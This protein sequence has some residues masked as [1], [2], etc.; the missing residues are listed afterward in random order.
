MF[1]ALKKKKSTLAKHKIIIHNSFKDP[2]VFSS[3]GANQ[4]GDIDVLL[5]VKGKLFQYELVS[6]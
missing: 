1:E 2:R 4:P 6:S 5:S 3:E